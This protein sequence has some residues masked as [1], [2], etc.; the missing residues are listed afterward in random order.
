M[1]QCVVDTLRQCNA[2]IE[3][4]E[5]SPALAWAVEKGRALAKYVI[6]VI[7]NLNH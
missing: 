1:R 2:A 3:A 7:D 4:G 6:W 5:L